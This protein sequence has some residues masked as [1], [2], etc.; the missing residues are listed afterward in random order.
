MLLR[1]D[2]RIVALLGAPLV[3]SGC[4]GSPTSTAT[5]AG[6]GI[7]CVGPMLP[8]AGYVLPVT[9]ERD[10]QAVEVRKVAGPDYTFTFTV[11]PGKFR[12]SAPGDNSVDL[13]AVAGKQ[14]AVVLGASCL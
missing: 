4:S 14:H 2:L 12:L 9:L 10:G 6:R 1:I 13:R 11:K 7:P 3:L 8:P 5:I